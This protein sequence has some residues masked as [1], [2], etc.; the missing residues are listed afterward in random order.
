MWGRTDCAMSVGGVSSSVSGESSG[1]D[2]TSPK[3]S[4]VQYYHDTIPADSNYIDNDAYGQLRGSAWSPL[5]G[6]ILFDENRFPSGDNNSCY[7][8]TGVARQARV[9]RVAVDG[10]SVVRLVGCAY[11]PFLRDFILFSASGVRGTADEPS[12]FPSAS[13]WGGVGVGVVEKTRV[14]ERDV[15]NLTLLGVVK[16]VPRDSGS[17]AAYLTFHGCAWSSKSSFWSFGPN[18]KGVTGIGNCLPA[19]HDTGLIRE[20]GHYGSRLGRPSGDAPSINLTNSNAKIG[21]EIGYKYECPDGYAE[22]DIGIKYSDSDGFK[23]VQSALKLFS[24]WYRTVFSRPILETSIICSDKSGV[25][26]EKRTNDISGV[27]VEDSLVV[28]LFKVSPAVISEGGVVTFTGKV[29]NQGS[30]LDE[31]VVNRIDEGERTDDSDD[32]F[33]EDVVRGNYA[34]CTIV[35]KLT[36]AVV[37]GF[38]VRGL[39]VSISA[40]DTVV[41]DAVYE[42]SCRYKVERD[43]SY[44]WSAP[45]VRSVAV[46]V[47]PSAIDERNISGSVGVPQL[48]LDGAA[49]KVTIPAG[50]SMV[51]VYRLNKG[52]Q[53]SIDDSNSVF[54]IFVN[55]SVVESGSDEESDKIKGRLFDSTLHSRVVIVSGQDGSI[56]TSDLRDGD[57]LVAQARSEDGSENGLWSQKVVYANA[58]HG[59]CGEGQDTCSSPG[60]PLPELP[61]DKA[62]ED[63]STNYR[64]RC[65]GSGGGFDSHV[66]EAAK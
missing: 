7:G 64:W 56:A 9:E 1:C 66:C 19:G 59:V 61:S 55:R 20:L 14:N 2:G 62:V 52:G 24:G 44:D 27:F 57:F 53:K 26:L 17:G 28:S 30:F 25:F 6:E 48:S 37:R 12:K 10:Q 42:L 8:L 29:S 60:N 45:L 23:F 3:L 16:E 4:R 11:V 65:G 32:A 46:K 40:F 63:T 36:G 21:Q 5:Y 39:N 49:V 33:R 34:Y 22:P 43:G 38:D 35:N 31:T 54:R 15:V 58:V 47:L 18:E 13:D 41:R 51:Y 50:V